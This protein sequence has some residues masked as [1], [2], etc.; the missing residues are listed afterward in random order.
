MQNMDP[1]QMFSLLLHTVSYHVVSG[2]LTNLPPVLEAENVTVQWLVPPGQVERY[3]ISW[4]PS[5]ETRTAS[6]T[7]AC[8]TTSGRAR[9]TRW[10]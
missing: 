6:S 2:Q 8:W 9:S 10:R 5:P 3:Y 4:H 1:G 7:A